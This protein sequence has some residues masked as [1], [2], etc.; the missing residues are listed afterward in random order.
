MEHNTLR[1]FPGNYSK[2]ILLKEEQDLAQ[3][4]AFT[5]QQ[6]EIKKTEE[7][8]RKYKAGIKSKQARGREKQL[9][10]LDRLEDVKNT[11]KINLNF[12]EVDAT[13][14]IVLA[15]EDL[16]MG[17]NGQGAFSHI[18]FTL[19]KGEKVALIGLNGTGKSTIQK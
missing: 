3:K 8:I 6:K 7:Y 5:K 2:Y 1:N 12:K 11:S 10:R 14:D 13:G 19:R 15:V 18:D 4:K 17:Y 9:A 16:A